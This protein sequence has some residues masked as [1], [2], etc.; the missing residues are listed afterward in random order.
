MGF[1]CLF[2]QVGHLFVNLGYSVCR[3]DSFCFTGGHALILRKRLGLAMAA[4]Y[5]LLKVLQVCGGHDDFPLVRPIITVIG[6]VSVSC[7]VLI[8]EAEHYLVFVKRAVLV[9]LVNNIHPAPVPAVDVVSQENVDM[10]AV[11]ALRAT[12]VAVSVLH[13]RF[14]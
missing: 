11:H 6:E 8:V 5:P 10:V 12:D 14:P 1:I 9:V 3:A 13:G 4:V 2:L 7:I